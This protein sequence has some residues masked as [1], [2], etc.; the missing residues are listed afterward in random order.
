MMSNSATHHMA[1]GSR[2]GTAA[3]GPPSNVTTKR[4]RSGAKIEKKSGSPEEHVHDGEGGVRSTSVATPWRGRRRTSPSSCGHGVDNDQELSS[5]ATRKESLSSL[6]MKVHQNGAIKK[7]DEHLCEGLPTGDG[8]NKSQ[9]LGDTEYVSITKQ[10]RIASPTRHSPID[11]DLSHLLGRHSSGQDASSPHAHAD[12]LSNIVMPSPEEEL[13][14]GLGYARAET[15][16][17]SYQEPSV[18]DRKYGSCAQ[19]QFSSRLRH[20]NHTRISNFIKTQKALRSKNAN[21]AIEFLTSD[22]DQEQREQL[23]SFRT[24]VK[25]R[26]RSGMEL[27]PEHGKRRHEEGRDSGR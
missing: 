4:T 16:S 3:S 19:Q 6:N 21:A 15:S 17:C 24:R 26:I 22:S 8:M 25:R 1:A 5:L 14:R 18:G 23:D 2:N 11:S 27:N 20:R 12:D 9:L 7:A 13:Q 10:N